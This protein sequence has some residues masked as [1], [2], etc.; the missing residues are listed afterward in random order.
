MQCAICG[1]K[2]YDSLVV[3][4]LGVAAG[5][6][7]D[8]YCFCYACWYSPHLGQSIIDML[9]FRHG[10]FYK[11]KSIKVKGRKDSQGGAS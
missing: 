10:I 7:G 8:D 5:M 1:T 6:S 11:R 2:D 9:G 3:H 4:D